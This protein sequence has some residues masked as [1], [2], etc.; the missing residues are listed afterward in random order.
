MVAVSTTYVNHIGKSIMTQHRSTPQCT[1]A[2]T[3]FP[4]GRRLACIVASLVLVTL[5][6]V[7]GPGMHKTAVAAPTSTSLLGVQRAP[8]RP[9]RS[10]SPSDSSAPEPR[11]D[12][13]PEPCQRTA[14]GAP[15]CNTRYERQE[16]QQRP[17]V[18]PVPSRT[19][20]HR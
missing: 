19:L 2:A 5:F 4:A 6:V 9:P 14:T 17:G 10:T 18:P 16:P 12:Q 20:R 8:S 13:N 1:H 15:G 11:S 7:T 3:A